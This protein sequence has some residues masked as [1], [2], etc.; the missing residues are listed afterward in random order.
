MSGK[1][2]FTVVNGCGC[3]DE[4][5]ASLMQATITRWQAIIKRCNFYL[6][7]TIAIIELV[8]TKET[9]QGLFSVHFTLSCF[10]YVTDQE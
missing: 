2:T 8:G 10:K 3:Y 9:N 6:K 1:S 5:Q 4:L 7:P